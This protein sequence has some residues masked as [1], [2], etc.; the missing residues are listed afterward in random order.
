[1][2]KYLV[3]GAS[4]LLG[5]E[6]LNI[7]PRSHGTFFSNVSNARDNMSALDLNNNLE[8]LLD[9]L[10]PDVVINCTG[11][12][13]VDLCERFP[14]K[15]WRL[16]CA[17]PLLIAQKCSVRSIKYVHISTDHFFNE[18]GI[19]LKEVDHAAHCNQYSFAK[20]SAELFV[21]TANRQSLI[22]RTNFFHFNLKSPKTFLDHLVN[23]I[24]NGKT[25][26]SFSDVFFTP[27][28]TSLLALYVKELVEIDYAGIINISG[29]DTLSKFEFH[30]AVLAAVNL[31]TELHL[32]AT[33][34]SIGLPAVRP[35]FMALDNTLLQK[36][37]GVIVP[38]VYDMINSEVQIDRWR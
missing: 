16:N 8:L 17:M 9:K 20:L 31:P 3:L 7:L 13:N 27:I 2:N 29:P 1:M 24:Q 18:S 23:E 33:L 30:N 32:P 26:Y 37:L 22:V 25:I 34:E 10:K 14:E 35:H 5:S 11:M 21:K 15:S 12:A 28:S 4:G 38:S 19:K 36:I 6:L